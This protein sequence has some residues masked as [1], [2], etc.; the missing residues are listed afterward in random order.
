MKGVTRGGMLSCEVV[1][2]AEFPS[3]PW[4]WSLM[5]LGDHTLVTAFGQMTLQKGFQYR[6]FLC[7]AY[8]E[9]PQL[10]CLAPSVEKPCAKETSQ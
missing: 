4:L 6:N 1:T 9:R 2:K 8:K 3:G 10:A 5:D 7:I